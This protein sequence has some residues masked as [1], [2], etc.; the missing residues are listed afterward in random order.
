L[1]RPKHT[2]TPTRA[3]CFRGAL[4]VWVVEL[5]DVAFK[6]RGWR[7]RFTVSLTPRLLSAAL[8]AITLA[9]VAGTADGEDGFTTFRATADGQEED[10]GHG[11]IVV[12]DLGRPPST[13]AP[14]NR[15]RHS[16]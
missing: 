11:P 14:A 5:T 9:P 13:V 8:T 10:V 3:P 6:R 1:V 12:F 2:P 16:G 15:R 7:L 4:L